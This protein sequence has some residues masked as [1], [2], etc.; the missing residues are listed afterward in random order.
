MKMP[1]LKCLG[2]ERGH[3][4]ILSILE[5]MALLLLS[6][7]AGSHFSVL[8]SP[9]HSPHKPTPASGDREHFGSG[10]VTLRINPI[11]G[12][13]LPAICVF[14]SQFLQ[15][16]A[17]VGCGGVTCELLLLLICCWV[18][19]PVYSTLAT[20]KMAKCRF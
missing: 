8:Q 9:A 20:L 19:L 1:F 7:F 15:S 10:A 16:H 18:Q 14:N 6:C 4:K 11:F 2:A 13:P 17:R 3:P 5:T 12:G